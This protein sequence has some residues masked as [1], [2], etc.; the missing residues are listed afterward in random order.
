MTLAS[1]LNDKG[2]TVG[3]FSEID[4]TLPVTRS[5][6]FLRDDDGEFTRIEALMRALPVPC[7]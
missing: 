4:T 5:S 1:K 2:Q 6:G 7:R 3:Y